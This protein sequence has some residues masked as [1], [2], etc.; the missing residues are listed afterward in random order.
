MSG[1]QP[2]PR[3][4]HTSSAA[5]GDCLYVFGGGDKGAE[6][7]KDQRLHVFDTGTSG[8]AK[9]RYAKWRNPSSVEQEVCISDSKMWKHWAPALATRLNGWVGV[10]SL[11]ACTYLY[12][13]TG[14]LG[15][16]GSVKLW[17]EKCRGRR[18]WFVTFAQQ[19]IPFRG[20]IV[21]CCSCPVGVVPFI[22]MALCAPAFPFALVFPA[23]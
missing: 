8:C 7:V 15:Q 17:D 1:V 2:L 22:L 12:V 10:H 20:G 14:N 11:L 23:E 19:P 9:G 5:V 3:T 4:F 18:E 21:L 13:V 6:P 16:N